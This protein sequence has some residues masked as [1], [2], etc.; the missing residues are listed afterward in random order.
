[1]PKLSWKVWL[2]V[3]LISVAENAFELIMY[4]KFHV[5]EGK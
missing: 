4:K 3:I 1:M 2:L 5:L